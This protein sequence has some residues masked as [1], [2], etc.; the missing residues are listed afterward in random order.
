MEENTHKQDIAKVMPLYHIILYIVLNFNFSDHKEIFADLAQV[1]HELR[2]MPL[3]FGLLPHELIEII[4]NERIL[5]GISQLQKFGED[6]PFLNS[7]NFQQ[8]S[9][10]VFNWHQRALLFDP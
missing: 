7:Y 8:V 4:D 6:F 1:S 10:Q 9:D 5:P 3:P 2:L